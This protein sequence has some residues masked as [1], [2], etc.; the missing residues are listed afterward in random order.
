MNQ[1]QFGFRISKYPDRGFIG[2]NRFG[3]AD[4]LFLQRIDYLFGAI[5]GD[6][7]LDSPEL[8]Y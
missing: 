1:N 6:S 5:L 2:G 7:G 8:K 4:P 3:S